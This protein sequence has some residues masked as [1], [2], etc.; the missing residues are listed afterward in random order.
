MLLEA[1]LS[2]HW[3][4]LAR[5]QARFNIGSSHRSYAVAR[6]LIAMLYCCSIITKCNTAVTTDG[7]VQRNNMI[8]IS[9]SYSELCVC[10]LYLETLRIQSTGFFHVRYIIHVGFRRID[11]V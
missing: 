11:S 3:R 10:A 7:H 4:S 6:K 2:H 8:E 9:R 1:F 5:R